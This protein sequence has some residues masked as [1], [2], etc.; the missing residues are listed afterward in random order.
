ML[1]QHS[2]LRSDELAIVRLTFLFRERQQSFASFA[3]SLRV[4]HVGNAQSRRTWTFGITEHVE[5]RNGKRSNEFVGFFEKFV[6]FT[7]RTHNHIDPNK[8][9]GHNAT[10]EF[11]LRAEKRGVVVTLHQFQHPIAT[12]LQRNVKVR[13]KSATLA[14][15]VHNLIREQVGLDARNAIARNALHLVKCL[16][17][18]EEIFTRRA[19]EVANVHPGQ[20]NFASACCCSIFGLRHHVCNSSIA[21]QTACGWNG[22]IGAEIIAAILHFEK[23]ACAL[24]SGT[25]R[26]ESLDI[27]ER[28]GIEDATVRFRFS[29]H[30]HRVRFVVFLNEFY[31]ASLLFLSHHEVHPFDFGNVFARKLSVTA[32]HGNESIGMF[33]MKAADGVSALGIGFARDTAR[34]DDANISRFFFFGRQT[35]A[36][37]ESVA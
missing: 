31:D 12:A 17:E 25:R 32:H 34:I 36:C 5:L 28:S 8:G 6:R 10:N 2:A 15:I 26:H 19:S 16:H 33:T 7:T 29:F 37:G 30:P 35:T 18:L 24:T 14:A 3:L 1:P 23:I 21:R 20:H 27:F 13:H 11:H 22:A 4:Y 9:I